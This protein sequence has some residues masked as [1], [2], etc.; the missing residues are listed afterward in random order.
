MTDGLC[1]IFSC[2]VVFIF[3]FFEFGFRIFFLL[4]LLK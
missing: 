3:V 2:C 1:F 4:A